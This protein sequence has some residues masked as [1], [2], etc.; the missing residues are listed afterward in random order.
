MGIWKPDVRVESNRTLE[1][2]RSNPLRYSYTLPGNR[3]FAPGSTGVLTLQNTFGQTV[4]AFMG[5]IAGGTISFVE[6]AQ[7]AD[8]IP[9]GT[10]W[11]ILTTDPAD[12]LPTMRA[13]GTV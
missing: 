7:I 9:R 1:L 5:S 4:G 11:T 3:V 6:T 10:S 13:Q 2:N 12:P 8:A